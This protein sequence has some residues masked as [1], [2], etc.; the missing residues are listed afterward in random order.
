MKKITW[1]DYTKSFEVH[2]MRT[3]FSPE[4][5][6]SC[7]TYAHIL[8][9]RKLPII[10]DQEHL[11]LLVGYKYEFILGAANSPEHFYRTFVIPKKSGGKRIINEPLPSLKEIQRW[12]LEEILNKCAASP[13][14]KA[15][16]LNRSIRDNAR[17][18]VRQKLVLKIDIKNFF[19]SLHLRNVI[20]FFLKSGYSL[21]VATLL[22]NLCC[23]NGELPQGAPTS[24][25]LSNILMI[26]ID[27]RISAFAKKQGIYYTR[28]ADDMTFSGDFEPGMLIKFVRSVLKDNKLR[29][30]YKK[31]RVMQ[32]GQRQEVT[33]VVV[34]EKIQAQKEM[35]KKL[36]QAI[37]YI[38]KYGLAS[39][40]DKT[41]NTRANHIYHLLG[42]ANF[43]LF[44]NPE[45][46]EARS[47]VAILRKY[48]PRE[49]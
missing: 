42:I 36:R 21:A 4:E 39:H 9:K 49:E 40:L 43:I 13:Y 20:G 33:G 5:I 1:A 44:L 28:Y 30:N 27:R 34:N 47:C 3:G 29:I 26:R 24:P 45:D 11:A 23:L 18:H 16:V 2:A 15:Y 8:Y 7:L 32:R 35:R 31:L 17:F 12:I 46:Q 25:A 48:I 41:E 37:Y 22:G 6:D 19:P 14:A 38:E 10:Y